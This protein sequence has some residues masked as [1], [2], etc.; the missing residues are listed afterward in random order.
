MLSSFKKPRR[1]AS[2]AKQQKINVAK[3]LAARPESPPSSDTEADS[4]SDSEYEEILI[5]SIN[6]QP[7]RPDP[8]PQGNK[9]SQKPDPFLSRQAPQDN[10][11]SPSTARTEPN[12]AN[13]FTEPAPSDARTE[14]SE[15]AEP[16]LSQTSVP[17]KPATPHA[18]HVPTAKPKQ[19]RKK[20][21]IKKYYQQRRPPVAADKPPTDMH[22]M[23]TPEPAA[24]MSYIGIS[25]HKGSSLSTARS[26][27]TNPHSTMSS[28][29]LNW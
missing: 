16:T 2:A 22:S 25:N 1:N 5:S 8:R 27:R 20:I 12:H 23:N 29:I 15:P 11:I 3:K 6:G 9:I 7:K 19:K 26:A 21:V 28:R 14:T 4:D 13:H 24:R 17:T 10:K 18:K